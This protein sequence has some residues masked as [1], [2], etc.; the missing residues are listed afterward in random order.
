M[1]GTGQGAV[2]AATV[3]PIDRVSF[4]DW[5]L[6][7]IGGVF[8]LLGLLILPRDLKTG[9]T[10]VVFFGP[11]FAWAVGVVVRKRRQARQ[12]PLQARVV[13]GQ[14]IRPSRWRVGLLG[15][16]LVLV[17]GTLAVLHAGEGW[18]MFVCALVMLGAGL[19]T[20]WALLFG[21]FA[22]TYL[23][24]EPAG[25]RIGSAHGSAL[26]PWQAIVELGRGELHNNAAVVLRVQTDA[27]V[28]EP[29]AFAPRMHRSMAS[30]RAL[31]GADF[32]ILS[33]HCGVDA[34]VLLATIGHYLDTPEDRQELQGVPR[35]GG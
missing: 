35:L 24:F 26:V 22:R 4:K 32:V 23:Q 12:R 30:S 27:V 19:W 3:A 16:G 33:S 13:G 28:A 21:P 5:L 2:E 10:S 31:I 34:T 15:G 29:P 6:V 7:L 1:R 9:L 20:L 25:L 18:V 11:C 14:A 8:T 17:G